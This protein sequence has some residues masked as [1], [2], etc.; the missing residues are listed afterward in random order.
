MSKYAALLAQITITTANQGIRFKE[1]ATTGTVTI[2]VGTYFLRGDGASDDI[3]LA[4][5]TAFDGLVVGNV[6]TV[7]LACSVDPAAIAA[8]VTITQTGGAAFRILWADALT[9]FDEALLGFTDAN[10]ADSTAAKVGTLSPEALWVSPDVPEFYEPEDQYDISVQRARSGRVRA[11]RRGGP[12]DVRRVSFQ[13]L[14][15][16]RV[17]D[18]DNTTDPAA[19]FARF[20]EATSAGLRF[21]FHATT[22]SGTTLGAL[23]SSTEIG[24]GWYFDEDTALGFAPERLQP[25]LALYAFTLTLLGYVA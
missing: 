20:L 23:S 19:T 12:Y 2:P 25:G 1:G 11:L 24:A 15:S 14:D 4:L 18:H 21:E 16:R 7:A 3:C 22:V 8:T 13:F 9:T 5:K 6:Y 17:I 10:T